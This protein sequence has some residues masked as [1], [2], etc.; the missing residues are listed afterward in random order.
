GSHGVGVEVSDGLV[1]ALGHLPSEV[2]P[3][4]ALAPDGRESAENGHPHVAASDHDDL[5]AFDPTEKARQMRLRFVH[6][7]SIMQDQVD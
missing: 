4:G 1:E 6:M 7:R 3:D 5:S 2:T